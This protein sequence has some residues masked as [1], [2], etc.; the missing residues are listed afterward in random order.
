MGDLITLPAA[1]L[2]HGLEGFKVNGCRDVIQIEQV[3]NQREA[4]WRAGLP[5]R[6]SPF[7]MRNVDEKMDRGT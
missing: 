6:Q 4:I 7:F 3:A 1:I 2:N 5:N